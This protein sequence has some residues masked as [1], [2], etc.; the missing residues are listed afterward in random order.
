M[1]SFRRIRTLAPLALLALASLAPAEPAAAQTPSRPSRPALR[2]ERVEVAGERPAVASAVADLLDLAPGVEID[3]DRLVAARERLGLSGWFQDVSISTRPGATPGRVILRVEGTLD[4][5]AHLETGFG[6]EPLEGWY[7]N[8]AGVRWN[9]SFGT[10]NSLRAGWQ[11]GQRRS[12]LYADAAIAGIFGGPLDLLVRLRTGAENWDLY[13]ENA[14]GTDATFRQSVERELAALGLRWEFAPRMRTTLWIG[15][16]SA[17]PG[18]VDRID[19]PSSANDPLDIREF[20]SDRELYADLGWELV[21]DHR[22]PTQPWRRGGWF[23]LRMVASERDGGGDSFARGSAELQWSLPLLRSSALGL[24]ARAA[25]AEDA[26]PYHLRPTFGGLATVRGYRESS[27]S[28]PLGA[29]DVLSVGLEWRTPL[30]GRTR[31]QPAVYGVLFVD[32]G[33]QDSPGGLSSDSALGVGWG[34]RIRLP[35]VQHLSLDAGIPLSSA[36][37]DDPYWVHAGLGFGF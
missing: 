26:A 9:H 16:S 18:D 17:R 30:I 31:P 6:H 8:V 37:T 5:S 14:A 4:R 28:G 21:A 7:L 25:W 29:R 10:G 11:L 23:A 36:Q 2:L 19:G 34:L 32:A 1:I 13:G 15:R 3:V 35:W 24:R 33:R 27:L 12:M 20:E 22:D